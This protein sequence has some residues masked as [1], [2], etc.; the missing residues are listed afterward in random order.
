M[1]FFMSLVEGTNYNI[2]VHPSVDGRISL[3]LKKVTIPEVL[4]TIQSVYG[5][6]YEKSKMVYPLVPRNCNRKAFG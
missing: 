1:A 2:T 6:D 4:E 3:Q 5:Y